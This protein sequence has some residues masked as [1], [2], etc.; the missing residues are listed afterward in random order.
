MRSKLADVSSHP[1]FREQRRSSFA[2]ELCDLAGRYARAS[3]AKPFAACSGSLTAR[4]SAL[5][6]IGLGKLFYALSSSSQIE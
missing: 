6:S 4:A 3:F 5:R 2:R 1:H